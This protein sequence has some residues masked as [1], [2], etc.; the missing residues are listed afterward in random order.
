MAEIAVEK[1]TSRRIAGG[2]GWT[3][4]DVLCSAGPR[5]RAFEEQHGRVNIAIVTSGTFQYRSRAGRE[6]MTPGSLLLGNSGECFECGH[7]HGTGDRCISFGYTAE[8]FERIAADAGARRIEFQTGRVPAIAPL[9]AV[10]AQA[11]AGLDHNGVAW[12]ELS[13][14]VAA[15]ALQVAQDISP[16]PSASAAAIARVTRAVR[17]ID[18]TPAAEWSIESLARTA[19]LS[20]FHFLRTFEEATGVTPHQYIRR[21]R[22]REAAARLKRSSAK[23]L[24]VALDC[25]F[26]DVSNFN[27]AFRAEFGM[28]PKAWRRR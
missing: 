22:L 2:R 8:F 13:L 18:R 5:D 24:D 27:R 28:A 11:R 20:A 7:E 26:G 17:E 15:R 25:G 3:V 21:V 1:I 14:E 4:D 16:G 6:M 19:G 10:V 9:S 12:E 23:V